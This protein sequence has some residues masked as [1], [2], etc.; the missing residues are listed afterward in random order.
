MKNT[1]TYK[2]T[3]LFDPKDVTNKHVNQS[4]WKKM[5]MVLLDGEIC[6]Y[7]SWLIEKRYG[8]VLNRPLRGAHISFIN[9]SINDIKT[10]TGLINNKDVHFVWDNLAKKWNGKEI[11]IVLDVDARSDGTHWWLNIPNE[12]RTILHN[13]RKEIGLD[14]PHWGLHMSIGYANERNIEHSK[15]IVNLCKKYSNEFN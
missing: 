7:Y 5:A 10:G 15:Y 3:I 13:I 8:L 9:D 11:D 2:G 12:E 6:E 4:S 14:R 1:I